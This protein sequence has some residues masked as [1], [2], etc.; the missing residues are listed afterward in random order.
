MS[1]VK[2]VTPREITLMLDTA[3]P[4]FTSTTVSARLKKL[5]VYALKGRYDVRAVE[6]EAPLHATALTREAVR[7]G[8]ESALAV[9]EAVRS[10][11]KMEMILPS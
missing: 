3:A 1:R 5:V 7:E 9:A 11:L 10:M 2:V 6:T 4:T 8:Y